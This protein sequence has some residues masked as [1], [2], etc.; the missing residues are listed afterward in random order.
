MSSDS[1]VSKLVWLDH[2]ENYIPLN[3]ELHNLIQY[4]FLNNQPQV[5][6]HLYHHPAQ[7]ITSGNHPPPLPTSTIDHPTKAM[8][9]QEKPHPQ[10]PLKEN[11]VNLRDG[12]YRWKTFSLSPILELRIM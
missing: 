5:F 8:I 6:H 7:D 10:N 11:K 12:S 2:R 1:Q 3:L 4:H 9:R